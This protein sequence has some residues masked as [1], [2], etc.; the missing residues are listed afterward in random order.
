MEL[1]RYYPPM[2]LFTQNGSFLSFSS[3]HLPH[4]VAAHLFPRLLHAVVPL[5][6][7]SSCRQPRLRPSLR[8][9]LLRRLRRHDLP[10]SQHGGGGAASQASSPALAGATSRVRSMRGDGRRSSK[11]D[12]NMQYELPHRWSSPRRRRSLLHRG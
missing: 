11:A 7:P 9:S 5:F 12:W 2:P 1:S 6:P 4:S 8:S 10:D 3:V